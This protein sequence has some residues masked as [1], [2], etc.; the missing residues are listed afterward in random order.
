LYAE[1]TLRHDDIEAEKL[2]QSIIKSIIKMIKKREEET[3]TGRMGG[4]GGDFLGQL[5][6]VSH[7][8][9]KTNWITI[10]DLMDDCKNFY[11]VEQ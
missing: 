2:D 3:R 4:Y 11:T 6:K 1:N 8:A 10:N 5:V 7:S 9:D